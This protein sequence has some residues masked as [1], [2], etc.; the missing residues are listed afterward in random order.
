[1][2]EGEGIN[3]KVDTSLPSGMETILNLKLGDDVMLSC[4]MI[5]S[6]DYPSDSVI[7]VMFKDD[8]VLLFDSEGNFATPGS[9]K[10]I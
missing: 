6:V 1:M 4:V 3:V 7:K 9:V 2:T 5:G 8:Q 10:F